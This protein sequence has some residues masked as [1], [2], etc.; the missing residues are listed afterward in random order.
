MNEDAPLPAGKFS[1]WLDGMQ[2]ALRG[3]GD[4]DVPCN[5]C[6][7]CCTSSQF[8][9]IMTDET[10]TLA[11][12]PAKLVFRAPGLPLGNVVLGHDD[13]GHCPML[14]DGG[15]SI[16]EHR[17]RACRTYDCRIFAATGIDVDHDDETKV[18]I[19]RRVRR[20]RFD[21]SGDADRSS[22]EAVLAAVGLMSEQDASATARAVLAIRRVDDV[23]DGGR[24]PGP[25]PQRA[26]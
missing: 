2:A 9:H 16:Y 5:G 26:Q 3:E 7:A 21:L 18:E 24:S 14:I 15:C 13:N 19:A 6:T 22:R 20:W 8:V 12:I 10:D 1:V 25:Q 17:P 11:H 4:A 23:G